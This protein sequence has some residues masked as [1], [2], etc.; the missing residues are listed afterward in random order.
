MNIQ[1]IRHATLLLSVNDK[2]LLVDPLLS[3]KGTMPPVPDVPNQQMNPLVD[4]PVSIEH[5]LACDAILVT[6]T[7]RD[8]LDQTAVELLPK[9]KPLFCQPDDKEQLKSM[10]FADVRPVAESVAWEGITFHR[11]GGKHGHG[12]LA[13]KMAPVSGFVI[14]SPVEPTVYIMGDTVWCPEVEQAIR[15]F[16]PEIAAANCGGA[17]F[18]YG[19]PITMS[20][21]DLYKLCTGYPDLKVV[22]IHLEAWN[23]CRV[24]RKDLQQYIAQEGLRNHFYIPADGETLIF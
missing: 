5:L 23:H 19:E 10:G 18:A 21:E 15:K 9:N 24:T 11:T 6:H 17:Q 14:A 13:L 2:K 4:L 12:L 22:A 8:H 3:P 20:T 1:L 7:H 16:N